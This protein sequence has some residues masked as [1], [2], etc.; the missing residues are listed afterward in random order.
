M[1]LSPETGKQDVTW[2]CFLPAGHVTSPFAPQQEG[3]E[4]NEERKEKK[5][6][7]I[8]PHTLAAK[9]QSTR[10]SPVP[11]RALQDPA[12][13]ASHH[14]T[15]R[16]P[17][18]FQA[19]SISRFPNPPS[20]LWSH[21]LLSGAVGGRG[22]ILPQKVQDECHSL[23]ELCPSVSIHGDL[24]PP[25]F[26]PSAHTQSHCLVIHFSFCSRRISP[27]IVTPEKHV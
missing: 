23:R 6:S 27:L 22:V 8:Q 21:M 3:E 13:S 18:S 16:L 2:P 26:A 14:P 17:S 24:S 20:P 4:R 7:C 19:S 10:R 15:S 12:G 9:P 25:S 1:S 11:P 5:P